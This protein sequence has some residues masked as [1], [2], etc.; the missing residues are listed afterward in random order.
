MSSNH[1]FRSWSHR[2]SISRAKT[3]D[4]WNVWARVI[5]ANSGRYHPVLEEEW[6]C[7]EKW[8]RN[9]K[10][11]DQPIF[12]G[13]RGYPVSSALFP[14]LAFPPALCFVELSPPRK[15]VKLFQKKSSQK[16]C[17]KKV[18]SKSCLKWRKIVSFWDRVLATSQPSVVY[19]ISRARPPRCFKNHIVRKEQVAEIQSKMAHSIRMSSIDNFRPNGKNVFLPVYTVSES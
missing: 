16:S 4:F 7:W 2:K 3:Y 15:I 9:A 12:R 14:F 13:N 10:Q 11:G 19:S 17:L 5:T 1:H 6:H 18:V 8:N